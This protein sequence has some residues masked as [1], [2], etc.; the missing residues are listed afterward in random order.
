MPI[1]KRTTEQQQTVRADGREEILA[2]FPFEHRRLTAVGQIDAIDA[3]AVCRIA[4]LLA[5]VAGC[6]GAAG[7][8]A[9]IDRTEIAIVALCVIA[10][11]RLASVPC[12]RLAGTTIGVFDAIDARVIDLDTR[13]LRNPEARRRGRGP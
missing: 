13:A 7:L 4:G 8:C 2:P 1:D 10:A 6:V 12:A 9:G 3:R 5:A 11:L